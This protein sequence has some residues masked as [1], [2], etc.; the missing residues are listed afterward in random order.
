[1]TLHLGRSHASHSEAATE[2]TAIQDQQNEL[3]RAL[4]ALSSAPYAKADCAQ[5]DPE[6]R[7]EAVQD[8]R[9]GQG[10]PPAR[11][12]PSFAF[13]EERETQTPDGEIRSRPQDRRSADQGEH[14]IRLGFFLW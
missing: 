4:T 7:R 8:H 10:A 14:A 3:S 12:A 9:H 13:R 5:Q 2:E 1:M 6:I 11:V